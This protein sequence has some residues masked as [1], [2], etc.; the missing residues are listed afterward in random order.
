MTNGVSNG[1]AP[2]NGVLNG[3]DLPNG[4]INGSPRVRPKRPRRNGGLLPDG[5]RVFIK[6]ELLDDILDD[7]R[8]R[9]L[10]ENNLPDDVRILPYPDDADL[11]NDDVEFSGVP[12]SFKKTL[13]DNQKYFHLDVPANVKAIMLNGQ[14][15]CRTQCN[16][17]TDLVPVRIN[18][19]YCVRLKNSG[20][21]VDTIKSRDVILQNGVCNNVIE[22]CEVFELPDVNEDKILEF[23]IKSIKCRDGIEIYNKRGCRAVCNAYAYI[24]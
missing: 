21:Y 13:K 2:R 5:D 18:I 9:E 11:N 16:K 4:L 17:K 8:D 19:Y 15:H 23:G 10:D 14:I 7:V 1:V 20:D 22:L 12:K 6:D 24:E 3:V